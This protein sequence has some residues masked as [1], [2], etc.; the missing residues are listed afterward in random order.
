MKTT[1][2]TKKTMKLTMDL[3][4]A[5][6]EYLLYLD[7]DLKPSALFGLEVTSDGSRLTCALGSTT[8]YDH[9]PMV[10]TISVEMVRCALDNLAEES[11]RSDALDSDCE[12]G[13]WLDD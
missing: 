12:S 10:F 2:T 13:L 5:I 8:V 1:T 9:P 6:A 4:T 7:E 3:G 11:A